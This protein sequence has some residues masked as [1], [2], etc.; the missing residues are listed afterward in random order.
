MRA[1]V[2]AGMQDGIGCD[3]QGSHTFEVHVISSILS[4]IHWIPFVN[5]STRFEGTMSGTRSAGA[6]SV[7]AL[8]AATSLHPVAVQ[9]PK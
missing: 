8:G 9:G 2:A 1:E 4:V 3:G 7:S 6:A 5:L